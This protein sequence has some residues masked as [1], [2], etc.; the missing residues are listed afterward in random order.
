MTDKVHE[1]PAISSAAGFDILNSSTQ[2]KEQGFKRLQQ[3]LPELNH[4]ITDTSEML[5]II[6]YIVTPDTTKSELPEIISSDMK[7]GLMLL[8]RP[9]DERVINITKVAFDK[10]AKKNKYLKDSRLFFKDIR[11]KISSELSRF[12]TI[13]F[14]PV[15]K[16]GLRSYGSRKI[17][18]FPEEPLVYA[19]HNL[20]MA[21]ESQMF[22]LALGVPNVI[23]PDSYYGLS[24]GLDVVYNKLCSKYDLMKPASSQLKDILLKESFFQ[25]LGTRLLH[26]FWD[27]N[28]RAFTGQLKFALEKKG[29]SAD[30]KKLQNASIRLGSI[31]DDMVKLVLKNSQLSLVSDFHEYPGTLMMWLNPN[32]RRDYMTKLR[33]GLENAIETADIP[34]SPYNEL[35]LKGVNIIE[36]ALTQV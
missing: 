28:G 20:V 32:V 33:G 21:S 29:I 23:Y 4:S 34:D 10:L 8:D 22:A 35:V 26:P 27:G 17:D 30:I 6:H 12:T 3:Q 25:I 19:S 16:G 18:G 5:Q 2:G 36:K 13:N 1:Q 24:T 7:L 15:L 9:D 11:D 14:N 31:S